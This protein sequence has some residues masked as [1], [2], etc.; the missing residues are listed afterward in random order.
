M[1]RIDAGVRNDSRSEDGRVNVHRLLADVRREWRL[2]IADRV[3]PL[4]LIII[5]LLTLLAIQA[6][7]LRTKQRMELRETLKRENA[8][9]RRFLE[10]AFAENESI[11]SAETSD[12]TPNEIDRQ[13]ELQM[14]AKSPDLMRYTE[15]IW[16]AIF[17]ASPLSSFS[18]GASGKWPDHY[19]HEGSSVTQSLS[20]PV[21]SNPLLATIGAFD[22]TLLVG[23]LLPLAVIALT[24][25]VVAMDREQGRWP[26]IGLHAT[27]ISWLV[28]NRCM[29]RV[30][31]L[32]AV[33]IGV[34]L[35]GSL[36]A[37]D[38]EWNLY[39]VRNFWV[40]TA[41]MTAY[42]AFWTL[43]AICVNSLRLSSSGSGLLLLL[44]WTFLVIAVP[45][46][47]QREVNR[48][49][50]I[51]PG[52]ELIAAEE[53]VQRQAEQESEQVWTEFLRNHPEITLDSENPQQEY[54][55]RDVALNRAIRFRVREQLES[56]QQRFLDRE[57]FLERYQGLSPLL[58]W[59]TAADQS[60]GASLRHYLDFASQTSEFHEK[61]ISYF[62]PFS[63]SGQELS[64]SDIQA[65]PRFDADQ[66]QT[67]LYLPPLLMSVCSLFVWTVAVGVFS[68][69][70]FR[71]RANQ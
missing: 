19:H 42:L 29:V 7:D 44:C 22:L 56:Y 16:W 35:S 43:L 26:L 30:G 61:Y 27:S 33:V 53:R 41:C 65:I 58:A 15:G 48:R 21:R 59:R 46:V 12:L 34:T 13:F 67:R 8:L 31:A 5:G 14:S 66:L 47:V 9:Q 32:I 71:S 11:D 3:V 23:A 1:V 52:S 39:S 62:E 68:W 70:S 55:L 18:M 49:F 57:A 54:L 45:S 24:Y 63:M 38:G 6:G 60:A 40:W 10:S 51:P 37:T 28:A 2:A 50:Q 36:I 4:T 69:W 17:P 25:N 20:R 64:Y